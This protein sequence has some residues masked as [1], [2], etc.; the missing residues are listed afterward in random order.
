MGRLVLEES[1][2][3]WPESTWPALYV[4]MYVTY[5]YTYSAGQVDSGQVDPDIMYVCM[6]LSIYLLL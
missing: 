1:G 3:T 6:Y 2:S 5:I 4:Y